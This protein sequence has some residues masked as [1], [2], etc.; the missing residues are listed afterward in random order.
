LLLPDASS[1]SPVIVEVNPRL[2]TSYIGYRK[3][4]RNNIAERMLPTSVSR[5]LPPLEWNLGSV[6]F[7]ATG[8]CRII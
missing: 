8:G 1:T 7:D 6:T 3:L 5:S 4:C 2:T